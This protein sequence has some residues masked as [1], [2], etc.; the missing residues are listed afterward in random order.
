MWSRATALVD[1]NGRPEGEGPVLNEAYAH[2]GRQRVSAGVVDSS[3]CERPTA[4]SEDTVER[5]DVSSSE[6]HPS[7]EKS[8]FPD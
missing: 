5:Q 1:P 2:V 4:S 6:N 7:E 3:L 8:P